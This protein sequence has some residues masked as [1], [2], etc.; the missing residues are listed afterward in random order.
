VFDIALKKAAAI[1]EHNGGTS[2]HG[3]PPSRRHRP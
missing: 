3:K 1:W 2:R